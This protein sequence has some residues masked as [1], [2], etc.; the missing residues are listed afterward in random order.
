MSELIGTTEIPSF[1]GQV[2]TSQD[3]DFDTARKVWNGV[4]DHCPAVIARCRDAEDVAA[5]LAFARDRGL[6]VSVRGGGHNFAGNACWPDSL[7]IDLGALNQV[8]VDPEARTARCGGGA[9][10]GELDAA[11][12]EHALAT[13]AGTIS[14]TGVGGLTLG[15]GFG[16]L[17]HDHGLTVDN[18]LSALMVLADGS[19]VEA[20]PDSEAD[21]FWAI[22]GGGGNF[23]V[24]TEF[25]FQLH[26]VGPMV[27]MALLFWALPQGTEALAVMRDTVA[28]LPPGMGAL[29]GIGL[30]APP[31]PFVP[32]EHHFA[33]GYALI[34]AGFGA[35]EEHEAV[36]AAA[37]DALPPLFEFATPMPYPALQSML[38]ESAPP[39]ILAYE[40]A[41]YVDDLS[42]DVIGVMTEFSGRKSSP[43]SFSPAFRMDGA[44]SAVPDDATAFGG[45]RRPAYTVNLACVAPTPELWEAD[46]AWVKDYWTA[47]RPFARSEGSY[48]NFMVEADQERIVAAYGPDKYQRL[49]KIKAQYDPENM[50]RHN[51]NIKP[52]H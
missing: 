17:T 41:L 50:F 51:A 27:R 12:A 48:V 29:L 40:R 43:M 9:R 49:A 37:R 22:R 19:I 35:A 34:L 39:G 18:L 16:W 36:V 5:A 31:A 7:V 23:G 26:P 44:Y 1:K 14:N 21:L 47:L 32:A 13:P 45:A 28:D 20:S 3:S 42:A 24:V 38:D 11:T 10:L 25:T 2:V 15:G 8:R 33:P 52:A 46:T 6:D 30:N 4:I